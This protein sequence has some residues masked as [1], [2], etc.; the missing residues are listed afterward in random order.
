MSR[1]YL[2]LI[3]R[4]YNQ[5]AYTQGCLSVLYS[6]VALVTGYKYRSLPG[7]WSY[8]RK[9]GRECV[10]ARMDDCPA[11]ILPKHSLSFAKL[12]IA[13]NTQNPLV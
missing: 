4:V 11:N 2:H 3:V 5:S 1:G 12:P 7:R 10:A 6:A 13:T 8:T 9:G